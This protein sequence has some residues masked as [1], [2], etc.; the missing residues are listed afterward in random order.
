M[1]LHQ[2]SGFLPAIPYVALADTLAWTYTQ[3]KEGT[4]KLVPRLYA[5]G[6]RDDL[7]IMALAAVSKLLLGY[8]FPSNAIRLRIMKKNS[9]VC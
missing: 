5:L 7:P 4:E 6:V 2:P 1:A 3:L 9:S 8:M